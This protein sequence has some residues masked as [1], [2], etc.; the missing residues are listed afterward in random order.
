MFQPGNELSTSHSR[1]TTP[2][3]A[4]GC[5]VLVQLVKLAG[6]VVRQL[7]HQENSLTVCVFIAN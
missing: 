6:C 3:L 1:C 2:L 5:H 4:V 7:M